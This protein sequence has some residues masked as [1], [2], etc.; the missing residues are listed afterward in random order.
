MLDLLEIIAGILD[1]WYARRLL[2]AIGAIACL[3]IGLPYLL[4]LSSSV[5]FSSDLG[6]GLGCL[7]IA[8]LLAIVAFRPKRRDA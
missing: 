3:V 2:A 8:V 1:A 6:K 7:A 5:D 4:N